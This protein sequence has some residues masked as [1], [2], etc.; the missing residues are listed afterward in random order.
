MLLLVYGCV[1]WGIDAND[2]DV[3]DSQSLDLLSRLSDNGF[4]HTLYFSPIN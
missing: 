2:G 4:I 3:P 1:Y